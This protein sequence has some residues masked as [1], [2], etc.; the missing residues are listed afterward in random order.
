MGLLRHG[1][2]LA[3]H[4]AHAPRQCHIRFTSQL[5]HAGQDTRRPN[6][7]S[8]FASLGL[9][10]AV[11]AGLKVAF[12]DVQK[13][14]EAQS[15]LIPAI[16]QGKDIIL[17]GHT[18]SGKS[19]GLVLALLSE[20]RVPPQDRKPSWPASLL[21]V[22][23]RDLAYQ[24]MHWIER[25]AA[26]VDREHPVTSVAQV[27]V[28]G[29][30]EASHLAAQISKNPPNILIATPQAILD[31]LQADERAVNLSNVSTVVVDEVD[32]MVDFIP[33][34]AS[35]EKKKKLAA[36]IKRHPSAGKLLLDQIYAQRVS[37]QAAT[38]NALDR[39]PQLVVCSATLQTGLRQQLYHN[40]WFKQGS[41]NIVKIRSEVQTSEKVQKP[42]G[43]P[44]TASLGGKDIQHCALVLTDDGNLEN[45]EGA[46]EPTPPVEAENVSREAMPASPDVQS[47]ELPEIPREVAERFSMTPSTFNPAVMEGVAS[48][49]AM[50]VPRVALLVLPAAAPVQRA[51]YDL[52]MLG[53]NAFGLD[54]FA[55]D[56]GRAHLVGGGA[57]IEENPT[58]LV[59]TMAST[60][61]LDLPDLSHVFV[62]GVHDVNGYVHVAGRVGRFG[63]GGKV[64]SILSGQR[65]EVGEDGRT[66]VVD[67]PGRYQRMLSSIGMTPTRY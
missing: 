7:P 56:R 8:S 62:V 44:E 10:K 64:V 61:G 29:S 52:R 17:K 35:K 46:M 57:V 22:P 16:M 1:L 39:P 27:L 31:V 6:P 54:L 30:G 53:V 43:S 24:F 41:E 25:I 32:Y 49:F 58:L 5:K 13:A 66:I 11:S 4:H 36:K 12:P 60:R 33:A 45:I 34:D 9:S 19:F 51:V 63:R 38:P 3:Q 67:E 23:H 14:T 50:D 20:Y 26:V 65:E 37:R 47:I 2:A 15:I 28:R 18:G 59:S 48:A 40:G 55:S 42:G 21:L